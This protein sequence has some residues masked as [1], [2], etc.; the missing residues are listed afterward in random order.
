MRIHNLIP[1]LGVTNMQGSLSQKVFDKIKPE[2]PIKNKI[3][4][5]QEKLEL[6]IT[7]LDG[8]HEK[9]QKKHDFVFEKIVNAQSSN[10]YPYAKAY[11]I[12]LN[13]IRKMRNMIG[14]A[15]LAMEQIQIRLNTV[16]ELGDVV[17]T[18]SPA[19]SIIKGLSASLG[20]IMPEAN[21]HM[22]DL[23]NILGDVLKGSAISGNNALGINDNSNSETLSILEEAHNIIEGNTKA[24]IPE[25]PSELHEEVKLKKEVFI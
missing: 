12:E 14:G 2:A 22:Q 15:K 5:A 19:M 6:Q 25:V 20:G 21:V 10:N 16:S 9:L 23:S 17:V 4:D 13:Q 11:A 8:I 18:L 24:T 7:K 1:K 3:D